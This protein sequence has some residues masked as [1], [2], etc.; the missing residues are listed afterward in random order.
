MR[1]NYKPSL[2]ELRTSLKYRSKEYLLYNSLH[3]FAYFVDPTRPKWE[4]W[5]WFFL[6][7]MS[8]ITIISIIV[9][10]LGK[11]ETDPTLTGF[12]IATEHI[13]IEFPRIFV[14]FDWAHMNQSYISQDEQFVYEQLYNWNSWRYINLRS[15]SSV[16]KNKNDFRKMFGMMAPNCDVSIT[17][18]TYKGD[19]VSCNKIFQGVLTPVGACCKSI[20]LEPLKIIDISWILKFATPNLIYPL[21]FYLAEPNELGPKPGERA[22]VKTYFPIDIKFTVDMTYSIADIGYLLTRQRKCFYKEEGTNLNDC[23]IN[24]LI[25]KLLARCKCLPWFLSFA[26]KTECSPSKYSCLNDV[27]NDASRCN[28]W[29]YCNHTS[30]TVESI[31]AAQSNEHQV[32][33]KGWPPA[34]Y[35][36]EMRF[37][38]LDL[39][40]SFGGIA[41][42]FIGYSL[43]TSIE[44]G[45]YFTLRMYC[46]AVIESSRKQYNIVTV[47]VVEKDPRK[48][49]INPIYYRFT[50]DFGRRSKQVGIWSGRWSNKK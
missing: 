9:F 38:Y 41:S 47:Y 39:L 48:P 33:L 34:I 31:K 16:Y 42:L 13:N 3:G 43:L 1:Y 12:D 36:R 8:V 37:G 45:Y 17:N 15:F 49:E 25:D 20:N 32:I 11:F 2:K 28:C 50:I 40:V 26:D 7:L 30:Y 29:L 46:G 19:I 5:L 10:V 35:R 21:R 44:F 23:E 6:T 24:C 27:V 18:C 4:R 22:T 14:C